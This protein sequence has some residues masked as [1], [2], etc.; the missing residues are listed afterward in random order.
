[1]DKIRGIKKSVSC[2]RWGLSSFLLA[3]LVPGLSVVLAAI[4]ISRGVQARSALG[5]EWNPAARHLW[6]G[7]R[8]AYCGALMS[9]TLTAIVFLYQISVS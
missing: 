5:G 6:W 7:F 4:A 3:V 2:F 8:L 9:L 1:M